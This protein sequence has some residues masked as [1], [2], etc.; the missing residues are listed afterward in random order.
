MTSFILFSIMS[1]RSIHVVDYDRSSF[2]F[3]GWIIYMCMRVHIP[4]HHIFFIHFSISGRLGYFCLLAILNNVFWGSFFP[5]FGFIP[6]L[7]DH[8][9]VL[10]FFPLDVAYGILVPNQGLNPWPLQWKHS[11]NLW[12]ARE[13]PIIYIFEKPPYCFQSGYTICMQL[14][15]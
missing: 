12:N 10:F 15:F 5:S 1:L 4:T 7:L 3:L 6:R 2:F 9:V 11:L 8:P 13:V 14:F